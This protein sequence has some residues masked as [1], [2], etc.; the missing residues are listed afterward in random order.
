MLPQ[1][2]HYSRRSDL[3]EIG[4]FVRLT[5]QTIW[6]AIERSGLRYNDWTARKEEQGDAPVLHVYLEP[7]PGP[8]PS[9]GEVQEAMHRALGDLDSDWADMERMSGMRPLRVSYLPIGTFDAYT[10]ARRKQGAE[11]AHLK[12]AHMNPPG[13]TLKLL[14]DAAQEAATLTP[15][16]VS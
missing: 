9:T 16:G 10:S 1:V 12:P 7:R 15:A 13:S 3:I 2:T 6:A 11:L 5:E 14:M 8:Q 4:G